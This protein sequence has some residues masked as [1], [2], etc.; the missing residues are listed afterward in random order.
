MMTVNRIS[1]GSNISGVPQPTTFTWLGIFLVI[2]LLMFFIHSRIVT[3][4]LGVILLGLVLM[5]Y[6]SITPALFKNPIQTG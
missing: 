6:K 5:N 2:V 3:I 4:F 1:T